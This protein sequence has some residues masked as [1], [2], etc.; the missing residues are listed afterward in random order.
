MVLKCGK[1]DFSLKKL[2]KKRKCIT[3]FHLNNRNNALHGII[4]YSS[5]DGPIAYIFEPRGAE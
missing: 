4:D 3:N 5:S 1:I 2:E